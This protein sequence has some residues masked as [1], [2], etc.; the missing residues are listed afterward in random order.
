M[1]EAGRLGRGKG[2]AGAGNDVP[3]SLEQGLWGWE[4][5]EEC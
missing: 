4:W 5:E 1:D 2:E 3:S